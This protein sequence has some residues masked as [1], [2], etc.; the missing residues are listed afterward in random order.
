MNER[1]LKKI[2]KI[3][4]SKSTDDL[5]KIWTENNRYEY[6]DETFAV[7]KQLLIEREIPIPQQSQPYGQ[8]TNEEK[9]P[10]FVNVTSIIAFIAGIILLI[11]GLLIEPSMNSQNSL[12]MS[13]G[14]VNLHKL[15]I[16]QTLYYFSGVCFIISAILYGFDKLIAAFKG[17]KGAD[18]S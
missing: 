16:K 7:I 11:I 4:E 6:Y 17:K 5:L 12:P 15:H 13:E 14:I 3:M 2:R 9:E 8:I 10:S 1:H 18:V